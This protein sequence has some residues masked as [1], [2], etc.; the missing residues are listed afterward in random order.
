MSQYLLEPGLINFEVLALN[1]HL[2]KAG[3]KGLKLTMTARQ[4]NK[5]TRLYHYFSTKSPKF[6]ENLKHFLRSIGEPDC[7]LLGFTELE[8]E[9][10]VLHTG[11]AM[12]EIKNSPDYGPQ[13]RITGW[14]E[15]EMNHFK[16]VTETLKPKQLEEIDDLSIPF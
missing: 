4:P 13:N 10:F 15:Q 3:H 6:Q 1:H 11:K 5:Q 16:D 2:S 8:L 7:D 9:M 14:V 12:V